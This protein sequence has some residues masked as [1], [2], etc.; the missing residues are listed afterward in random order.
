MKPGFAKR[1][2][3]ANIASVLWDV[4]LKEHNVKH[5]RVTY[6]VCPLYDLR[7]T[8]VQHQHTNFWQVWIGAGFIKLRKIIL[9][10]VASRRL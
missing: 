1:T 3:P 5:G 8:I 6:L 4:W 10:G 9:W 7:K 2:E